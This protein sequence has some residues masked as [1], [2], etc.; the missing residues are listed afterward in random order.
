MKRV[1]ILTPCY[2]GSASIEYSSSL[3]KSVMLLDDNGYAMDHIYIS[4]EAIVQSARNKLFFN[5]YHKDYDCVVWIDSDIEWNPQDLLKL[6]KSPLDVVGATYRRKTIKE[7]YVA[8]ISNLIS[9]DV[10][11]V[12]GIGFGFLKMSRKVVDALWNTN[13]SYEDDRSMCKN[14]FEVTVANGQMYSED[15]VV[16]KKIKDLG[17]NVYL[18]K[19]IDLS[20]TSKINLLGSFLNWEKQYLT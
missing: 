3:A 6:V 12:E 1:A 18:D 16:C 11:E 2:D 4:G 17:F 8:K 20:H 19:T 10:I 7:L 5:A 9:G 13:E 14:V 15:Y